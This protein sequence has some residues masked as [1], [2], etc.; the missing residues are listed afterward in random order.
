M[1]VRR[2]GGLMPRRGERAART[3]PVP[4]RPEPPTP[5]AVGVRTVRKKQS[6]RTE[7]AAAVDPSKYTCSRLA[8]QLADEWVAYVRR[9]KLRDGSLYGQTIRAFAEYVDK[10]ALSH[11]LDASKVTLSGGP[12]DLVE[13]IYA[14]E[15]SL[16][17]EYAATST[18]PWGL[19]NSLLVLIDSCA[20]HGGEVSERLRRRA[21]NGASF[22]KPETGV[23]EE[24]SNAERLALTQAARADVRAMEARLSQ[25]RRLLEIGQDPRLVHQGWHELPNL[26]WAARAG[27]LNTTTLRDA[28]SSHTYRW[29]AALR[30]LLTSGGSQGTMNLMREVSALLFP[31]ELDLQ[32]FRI[33]LTMGMDCAPEELPTLMLPDVVFTDGGVRLVQQ[34]LRAHR[35]RQRLHRDLPELDESADE[36]QDFAGQ[37][38]WDVPGLIRRLISATELT[39]VVFAVDPYLMVS[40]EIGPRTKEGLSLRAAQ[41]SFK[42]PKRRFPDWIAGHVRED[43]SPAL[44]ISLPHDVRRFRKAVKSARVAVLGGVLSDLAGDDH[45]V[46]TFRSHY[47]HG[48]TTYTLSGRAIN[49]AQKTVFSKIEGK[50]VLV[51]QDAEK[52][53]AKPAAAS[54]LGVTVPQAE[55]LRDGQLD[56]GLVN[57]RDPYDSPYTP[58][59]KLCHVAPAMCMLCRNAVIFTSQIPRLLML[60]DHIEHMKTVLDPPRWQAYWGKQAAALAEVFTEC[61][62]QIPQAR[63]QIEDERLRLDLPLGMRTE[64]DR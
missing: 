53:L 49:Q 34:K 35:I 52:D 2:G 60:S 58:G 19:A 39:R 13:V 63:Q 17:E 1:A 8:A 50:P 3:A 22:G 26:V 62:D 33:L 24:F 48:T 44:E 18:M 9:A 7:A 45:H 10:H 28:L 16:R 30:E 15:V 61:A 56:M 21:E 51:Q 32:A 37:G 27:L 4:P 36:P 46:E 38:V 20:V 23:L 40:V 64:Y 25:G 57:C 54:A 11:G 47:G 41:V 14:W 55:A 59:T 31:G 43:G 29:P 5:D 6:G 12:L 42:L